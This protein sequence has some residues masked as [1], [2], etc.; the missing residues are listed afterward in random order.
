V[1][2]SPGGYRV[3]VI[4]WLV[5]VGGTAGVAGG[6]RA[7]STRRRRRTIAMLP[8]R[9]PAGQVGLDRFPPGGAFVQFSTPYSTSSR[10][11]LNRLAAAAAHS[12]GQVTV[13]ELGAGPAHAR[14]GM[15]ATPMVL[16]VDASGIVR[17]RWTAPPDRVELDDLFA[18]LAGPPRQAPVVAASTAKSLA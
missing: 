5:L 7:A 16:Y 8:D 4:E 14:L 10:V 18:S 13:I 17:R 15:R 9:I 2:T 1:G 12:G 6:V 11:S 3:S